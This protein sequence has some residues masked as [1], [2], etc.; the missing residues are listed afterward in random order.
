MAK[1]LVRAI[2]PKT[3][4][5]TRMAMVI[6]RGN[7]TSEQLENKNGHG[8][9]KIHKARNKNGQGEFMN[10]YLVFIGVWGKENTKTKRSAIRTVRVS[11]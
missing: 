2:G 8:S 9:G 5:R 4:L 10:S 1:V 11:S 6:A 7:S 3:S